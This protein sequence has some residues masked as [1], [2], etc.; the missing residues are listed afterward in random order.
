MKRPAAIVS[1]SDSSESEGE[2]SSKFSKSAS[3]PPKKRK[4]PA[5][6][7]ELTVPIPIDD[8]SKHQG[9]VRTT[10]HVEGQWAA[11]VYVPIS[12]DDPENAKL[13]Q[14][15]RKAFD[16]AKEK[17]P[18]LHC[19]C[20]TIA[21]KTESA[22]GETNEA[23][24]MLHVSLTRPFFLRAHQRE[25]VKRAIRALAK[26]HKQFTASFATFSDLTNDER[27]R[28][29]LCMEVGGGHNEFRALS[30]A[31]T[32]TLRAFKQKEYYE[33]PRFHA[34]FA[35]ALLERSTPPILGDIPKTPTAPLDVDLGIPTP[36]KNSPEPSERSLHLP[37]PPTAP[38][39]NSAA[40]PAIGSFP[41][42]LVPD[43]NADFAKAL[44]SPA[45]AFEV[46]ELKVKIGKDVFGWSL[47]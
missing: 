39:S 45:C 30:D 47:G 26:N 21:G 41:P 8:P 33:Q 23:S 17:V 40:F 13:K 15:V 27:T 1:Y 11:Y 24:E 37:A 3:P 36:T 35:W 4:L 44:V 19:L 14:T 29:F 7:Q 6:A 22:A 9:R 46:R 18:G 10:P 43:L 12:L 25:E 31:L 28:T 2:R 34:S 16:R 38:D 20:S 32:P 42:G 5:L